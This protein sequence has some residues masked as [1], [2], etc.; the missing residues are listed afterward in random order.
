LSSRVQ[1]KLKG[2]R[3]SLSS[4]ERERYET[5]HTSSKRIAHSKVTSPRFFPMKI[6]IPFLIFYYY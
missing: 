2:I 1:R 4:K 5:T 3:S 6:M